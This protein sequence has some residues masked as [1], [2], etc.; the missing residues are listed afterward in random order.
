MIVATVNVPAETAVLASW[1]GPTASSAIFACVTTSSFMV[2]VITALSE[3]CAARIASSAI[4]AFVTA[5]SAICAVPIVPPKVS[6]D[7]SF[8]FVPSAYAA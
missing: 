1:S 8:K 6:N 3:S 5:S 4:F 7:T 2:A